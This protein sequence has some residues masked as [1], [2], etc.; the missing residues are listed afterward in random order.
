[1]LYLITNRKS[2]KNNDIYNV[3]QEAVD[4]GVNAIILREKDLGYE[5]LYTM[6]A[7]IK[8]ITDEKNIPLIINGNID[9][10]IDIKCSGFHTSFEYFMKEKIEFNGLLGVSV[11]SVEEAV[12]A[13]SHGAHYIIAGHIF[14]TSC[15]PNLKPRGIEFIENIKEKVKI[16]IIAIGGI[17]K[18]NVN[19]LYE[20]GASGIAVMS[21]I[22]ESNNIYKTV[23][24]LKLNNYY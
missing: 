24:E 15:K 16:P 7:K 5:D 13:Q 9:V 8:I 22:M 4:A 2:I 20:V 23:K 6:A 14:S 18:D 3:I 1:M 17:N 11:H 21:G 12:L 10:A 19:L